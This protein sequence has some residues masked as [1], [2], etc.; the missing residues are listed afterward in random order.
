[1]ADLDLTGQQ[2]EYNDI[3]PKLQKLKNLMLDRKPIWDKISV[4]KRKKW[5]TSDKDPIMSLAYQI[6]EWLD[7][8][9]FGEKYYDRD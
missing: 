8:R 3:A 5:V 7:E 9:F 6:H 1:M 4:A 2:L